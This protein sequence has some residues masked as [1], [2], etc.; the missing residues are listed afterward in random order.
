MSWRRLRSIL[1][2]LGD[3][4]IFNLTFLIVFWLRYGSELS[5]VNFDPY[6]RFFWLYTIGY[7]LLMAIFGLYEEEWKFT[8]I[9]YLLVLVPVIAGFIVL[10]LTFIFIIRE[11]GFPRLVLVE[12]YLLIWILTAIWHAWD[13][14][15]LRSTAR[16]RNLLL[17]GKEKDLQSFLQQSRMLEKMV[18]VGALRLPGE[19]PLPGLPYFEEGPLETVLRTSKADELLLLSSP[20]LAGRMMEVLLAAKEKGV[21][22]SLVPSLYDMLA[23]PVTF[24]RTGD[25]PMVEVWRGQ[26]RM[27]ERFLKRT[28]DLCASILL[29]ALFSPFMLIAVLG[30]KLSSPGPLFF[31]QERMGLGGKVFVTT[32]FRS[33]RMDAEKE[34]GPCFAQENDPRTFAFGR[35]LRKLR[36][37]E[38]PQLWNVFKGEMS[39]VGPRPERPVFIEQF[40][41][42]V[43]G[44]GLRFL[45]KPGMTGMAQ[46]YGTYETTPENKLR[47][48][49]SYI[50]SQSLRADL[51]LLFLTFKLMLG[52]KGAR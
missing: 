49:L 13:S 48:D 18:V 42:E 19:P 11:F 45:V 47:Y 39:L 23:N 22:V 35:L 16:T 14:A 15:A 12:S 34:T 25:V 28:L 31:R 46:I 3:G 9:D 24:D 32:K 8:L 20:D 17:L 41:K 29:L 5:A 10:Q 27:A 36:I 21:P 7:L 43:P 1:L 37:D 33:M 30:I 50:R 6:A 2:P 40:L 38:L 51:R 4:L 44:Y 52:R 26:A